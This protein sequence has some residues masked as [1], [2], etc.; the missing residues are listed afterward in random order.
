VQHPLLD[1]V[2]TKASN[3]LELGSGT[4]LLP[5]LLYDLFA[6]WIATDQY[7]NLKLL[8]R[9][10]KENK[11]DKL[12]KVQEVDWLHNVDSYKAGRRDR[13][14]TDIAYDLVVAVD[15]IYNEALVKP[16]VATL[17]RYA[18]PSKTLVWVVIELR[19]S[20][21]VRLSCRI[22]QV[23]AHFLGFRI[24]HRLLRRMAKPSRMGDMEV[25][26]PS[27]GRKTR[28]RFCGMGR[29]AH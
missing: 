5:V 1:P 4:G 29:L 25:R 18:V 28:E 2:Q 20:D 17:E 16:F 3:V 23:S 6:S 26:R 7:D 14:E 9:N 22:F 15:C 11:A 21:T 13:N 8:S 24:G 12:V 10:I 27:D 19:S